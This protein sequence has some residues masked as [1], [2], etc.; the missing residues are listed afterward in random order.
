[1]VDDSS[2]ETSAIDFFNEATVK[3]ESLNKIRN[4]TS[5]GV[6]R[7]LMLGFNHLYSMGC[8]VLIN[9]DNDT[10]VST[11]FFKSL[12]DLH[13]K[14]PNE[15]VSGF[16]TRTE[17]FKSKTQRH[18]I[19]SEHDDYVV[20]ASIGGI[21]LC[22]S[23]YTYANRIRYSLMAHKNWD[24]LMSKKIGRFIISTP[25]VVQ[26]TGIYQGMHT[27]NPDLAF[28]FKPF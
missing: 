25:S 9:L 2:H 1:M 18:K 11:L 23:R 4:R 27:D 20:K 13:E 8:D 3:C 16:D 24:W 22:F 12:I 14:F 26:H 28:N 21:N 15:I 19:I 17:D 5:R 10:I 7:S 6:A